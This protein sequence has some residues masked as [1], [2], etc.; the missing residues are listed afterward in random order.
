MANN[1]YVN[2]VQLANGTVLIDI[3]DTTAAASDVA[4]GKVF[5]TAAG[6][7]TTGTK[8]ESTGLI[9]EDT[10]DA[11]G[12]T[13]R[14]ITA[15]TFTKE[16]LN[17]L[18]NGTYNAPTGQLYD[19]V[20]VTVS[21][22]ST[23]EVTISTSGSV[24]QELSPDTIYHFTSESLTSLTITLGSGTSSSQYHFDFISPSTAVTLNLP[25]IVIMPTSFTVEPNTK[26]EID[27]VNNYGVFAQWCYEVTS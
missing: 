25:Q 13:I 15:E 22:S 24:S 20:I 6:V 18:E 27:I 5:Y 12:G 11:H 8:T 19:E 1:A 7:P 10:L 2:K 16:T 3:S 17:V 21:G 23:S 4:A 26:Y 14:Q 9:I